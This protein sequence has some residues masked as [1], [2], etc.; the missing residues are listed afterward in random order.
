[1][2][3]SKHLGLYLLAPAFLFVLVFF[4]VPVFLT[5][6]FGFTNMSTA[7]GITGG[8]YMATQSSMLALKDRHN[9]GEI[10]GK[11]KKVIYTI[12]E[13]GLQAATK[14]GA[15]AQMLSELKTKFS[16]KSFQRR[17]DVERAIKSPVRLRSKK[18]GARL[19]RCR[20]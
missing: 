19:S 9:L 17:R 16:G 4:V 1:M 6:V 15:N 11:L 8:A 3:N 5:G 13:E 10:A 2:G 7:T 14:Q 12:D 20:K 18:D